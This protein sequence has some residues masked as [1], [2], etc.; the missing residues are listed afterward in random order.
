MDKYAIIVAGGSGTR[1]GS[2]MPKQFLTLSG[3]PLLC[4]TIS[5]F[6]DAFNETRIILVLP[7]P[8]LKLAEMVLEGISRPRQVMVVTGGKTRFESVKNGLAHIPDEC[9]VFVH[10]GVR[11]LTSPALIRRC[12]ESAVSL[13]N[14]VPA[15]PVVDSIRIKTANG[16]ESLD[17]TKIMIVQTPQTFIGKNIKKAYDREYNDIFTDDASVVE[18]MGETIHLVEGEITNIKITRQTD[19]LISEQLLK[20]RNLNS[21]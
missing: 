11:C 10:D 19:L 16:S 12:Y 20:E 1:M 3:K 9:V 5:A 4:Y 21:F 6:L 15:V 7:E 18:S 2:N 8:Y 13:G 17:R 14:A